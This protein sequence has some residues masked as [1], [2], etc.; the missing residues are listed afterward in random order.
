MPNPV[1]LAPMAGITDL[2]YRLVMKRFGAALVFTE[3]I[4]ACSLSIIPLK[5]FGAA[6]IS[7]SPAT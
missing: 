2:P 3:M 6:P 7:S 4:S 5:A 1:I